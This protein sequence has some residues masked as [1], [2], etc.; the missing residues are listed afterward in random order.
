MEPNDKQ[1][2]LSIAIIDERNEEIY[3]E[4]NAKVKS[5]NR[6][7]SRGSTPNPQLRWD[8][9]R[10]SQEFDQLV[11]SEFSELE[12]FNANY[13]DP[14]KGF[15][16]SFV[17]RK[18]ISFSKSFVLRPAITKFILSSV[19]GCISEEDLLNL[20]EWFKLNK[21]KTVLLYI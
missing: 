19:G 13:T 11:K 6:G 5:W 20:Q 8:A 21:G 3:N 10:L 7:F 18:E 2:E 12:L 4:L 17:L 15:G 14:P 16:L 9:E 1:K